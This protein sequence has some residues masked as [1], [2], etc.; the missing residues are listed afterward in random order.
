MV[1][2]ISLQEEKY[3]GPLMPTQSALSFWNL[4]AAHYAANP[5]V[6]FDLYNEPRLTVTQTGGDPELLWSIWRNGG[7]VGGMT[8]VGMQSLVDGIRATGSSNITIAEGI[9]WATSLLGIPQWSLSG[10][11]IAYGIKPD[12]SGTAVGPQS[13]YADFGSV[14]G[15]VPVFPQEFDSNVSSG[16]CQPNAPTL[17]PSLLSYLATLQLGLVDYSM[18]PGN[19]AI[20]ASNYQLPT[21]YPSSTISCVPNTQTDPLNLIGN[22]VDLQNWFTAH[23]SPAVP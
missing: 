12:L 9:L 7:T 2:V 1:A 5:R 13:W 21:S 11:N 6:F 4:I 16:T 10:T 3:N 19:A 23:S 18:D 15:Q 8:Y 17:L 14:A 22:G 20:N